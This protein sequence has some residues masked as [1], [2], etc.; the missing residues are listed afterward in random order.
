LT[1][2][3]IQAGLDIGVLND[4]ANG[5]FVRVLPKRSPRRE[6]LRVFGGTIAG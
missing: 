4:Y 6:E 5:D 1:R 3:Q 2:R